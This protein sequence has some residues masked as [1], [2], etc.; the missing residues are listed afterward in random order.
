MI[1]SQQLQ[2]VRNLALLARQAIANQFPTMSVD[3]KM[4]ADAAL[5]FEAATAPGG[6]R[7]ESPDPNAAVY[8][9]VRGEGG[10]ALHLEPRN[11]VARECGPSM[12]VRLPGVTVGNDPARTTT[13]PVAPANT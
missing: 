9:V 6:A 10:V 8:T 2:A 1:P 3:P 12:Q 13:D 11:E 7:V 5:A 4:I